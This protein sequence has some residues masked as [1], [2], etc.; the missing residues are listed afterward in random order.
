[1]KREEELAQRRAGLSEAKKAALAERLQS[2]LQRKAPDV[3]IK[4]RETDQKAVLSFAQQRLWFLDQLAPGNPFYNMPMIIQLEGCLDVSL[5]LRCLQEI[6]QRHESLRTNF[7]L[8]GDEPVQVV[9]PSDRLSLPLI[10]LQELLEEQQRL[11]VQHLSEI[12]AQRPFDLSRDPLMRSL[13][14]R[15]KPQ[16]HIL[17]MTMHHIVSDGWS[18]G[19]LYHEMIVLYQALR[20]GV[21]TPLPP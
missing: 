4:R 11:T 13:L 14:L 8:D 15:L 6:V 9:T 1:M 20:Q 3:S 10:D 12:E 19:I 21:A 16:K 2:S 5:L 7:V 17:L 18:I